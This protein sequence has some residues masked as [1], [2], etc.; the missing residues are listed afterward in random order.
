MI[1][2]RGFDSQ[3]GLGI[4]F[5][6]TASRLDLG[7][8]QP[9]IQRVPEALSP[10]AKQLGRETDHSPPP[11]AEVKNVWRYTSPSQSFF[12]VWCLVKHREK[13]TSTFTFTL[14]FPEAPPKAETHELKAFI[15]CS[16]V[17]GGCSREA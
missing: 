10:S 6:S 13:F 9:P 1:G 7:P 14:A 17:K 4:F 5:F 12:T 16:I 2:V 15:Q 8:T 11:S 3:R